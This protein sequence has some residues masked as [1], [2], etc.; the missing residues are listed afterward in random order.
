MNKICVKLEFSSSFYVD[1]QGLSGGLCLL[2]ID[3]INIS[4][5]SYSKG[6]IVVKVADNN[7]SNEWRFTGFYD[8]PKHESRH[9]S[10]TLLM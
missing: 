10:W 7:F 5:F 2:W 3:S 1:R 8:N 4:L 6:H 9:I